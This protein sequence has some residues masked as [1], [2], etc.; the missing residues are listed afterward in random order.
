[1]QVTETQMSDPQVRAEAESYSA[2]IGTLSDWST[3]GPVVQDVIDPDGVVYV[4][5]V[6]STDLDPLVY[7][8]ELVNMFD[9]LTFTPVRRSTVTGAKPIERAALGWATMLDWYSTLD[10]SLSP[11]GT[12]VEGVPAG[13]YEPVED[14]LMPDADS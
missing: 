8:G 14:L 1:M 6:A 9:Q 12:P 7:R 4:R 13:V 3:R 10:P 2:W 5:L 11:D